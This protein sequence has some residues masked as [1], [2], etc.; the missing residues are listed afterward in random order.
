MTTADV[1][2]VQYAKPEEPKITIITTALQRQSAFT[3]ETLHYRSFSQRRQQIAHFLKYSNVD[4]K[5]KNKK[6]IALL[7]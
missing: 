3:I 1:R 2:K 5:K 6:K 7:P 4:P